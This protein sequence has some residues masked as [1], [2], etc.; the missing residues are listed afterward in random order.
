V[1]GIV[2]QV[3]FG[4]LPDPGVLPFRYGNIRSGQSFP[5]GD[6]DRLAYSFPEDGH[7]DGETLLK[8]D[9]IAQE[10]ITSG[11]TPG[12]Y[13]LVARHGKVIYDKAFGYHI[14]EQQTPVSDQTIYDLAS[15]T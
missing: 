4:G 5:T 10:A 14:Y 11:S 12:C 6:L 15:I 7:V 13:V 3:I 9:Q 1:V 2:P 8:I